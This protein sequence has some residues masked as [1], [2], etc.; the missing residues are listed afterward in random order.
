MMQKR[1]L[2]LIMTF[3]LAFAATSAVFASEASGGSKHAGRL[4]AKEE[5]VYA[6]LEAT[7]VPQNVYVVNLLEV[8]EAGEVVDYGNYTA[9][10]NLTDTRDLTLDS[11]AVRGAAPA[12][13]GLYKG[14]MDGTTR[15][16]A[17]SK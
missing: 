3:V 7:G 13:G 2:A 11:G 5:V 10:T 1:V 15:P 6:T 12:G 17:I 8:A 4:E 14:K 9:V 16:R